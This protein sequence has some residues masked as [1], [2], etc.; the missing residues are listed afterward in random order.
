LPPLHTI[1]RRLDLLDAYWR[2][3]VAESAD[4][5]QRTVVLTSLVE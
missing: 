5:H 4:H 2:A 3:R 1:R